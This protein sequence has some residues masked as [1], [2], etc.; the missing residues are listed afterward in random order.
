MNTVRPPRLPRLPAGVI[1]NLAATSFRLGLLFLVGREVA[2]KLGS[3]GI[4][5]M[6]QLQNI[7]SLGLAIASQAM[8]PGIQQ[9]LGSARTDQVSERS[10]WALASG[11]ILALAS[12]IALLWL[13]TSGAIYL[14]EQ[15]HTAAWV[16]LPGLMAMALI[17]NLQAI[18]G[19][20]GKLRQLNLFIAL[21]GPFQALWL[22]FWIR[23]G[24]QGLVPGVLL[25]GVVAL[26]LALWLMPPFPLSLPRRAQWKEQARLWAPLAAM[27]S[28]VAVLSPYK[29]ILFR[30]TI[31]VQGV[32]VAGNWQAGVR[33]TDLLFATWSTAFTT[34]ALPRL[35]GPEP[36]RPKFGKLL[37]GP[38]GSLALG[39]TIAAA[40]PWILDLAYMGRFPGALP[41]LRLQCL[42]EFVQGCTVPLGL[43]LIARRSASTFAGLELFGAVIQIALVRLLVPWMGSLGAP[44][45]I[46]IESTLY[47][48]AALWFV[49][50]AKGA[51]GE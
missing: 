8:Q 23:G 29:L 15:V 27:G 9:A 24:L 37:L 13:S 38:L 7:L 51:A 25:F 46:M 3:H 28:V 49:K 12:G 43:I 44:I 6:G 32:E 26:P 11:Q 47:F 1:G 19:G 34:W 30:E 20:K 10:S 41:V 21:S 5:V 22:Y 50:R 36:G 48:G 17:G 45:A 31:L 40:A 16:L 2:S 4:V 35:S 42:A 18:A 14:P 33:I 39:T